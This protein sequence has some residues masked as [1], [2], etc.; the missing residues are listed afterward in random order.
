MGISPKQAFDAIKVLWPAT[1]LIQNDDGYLRCHMG[2]E[3]ETLTTLDIDWKNGMSAWPPNPGEGWRLIDPEKDAENGLL[4]KSDEYWQGDSWV[5]IDPYLHVVQGNIYRRRV[6]PVEKWRPATPIDAIH[7]PPLKCRNE[8]DKYAYCRNL[9]GV[10][11]GVSLPWIC[12]DDNGKYSAYS[13]CEVLD[14]QPVSQE[15]P[16]STAPKDRMIRMLMGYKYE[17]GQWSIESEIWVSRHNSYEWD[18][19]NQ[20]TAWREVPT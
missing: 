6:E 16:M 7:E 18:R 14:E 12:Q 1:T 5:A 20:P 13:F 17:I 3:C 10:Q 4:K 11:R 8:S 9:I 15:Q 19:A 2:D